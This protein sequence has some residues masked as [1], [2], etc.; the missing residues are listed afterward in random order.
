M[1]IF[2]ISKKIKQDVSIVTILCYT[3][4][5]DVTKVNLNYW[6]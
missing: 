4:L 2:F 5:Q 3:V 6:R 1:H